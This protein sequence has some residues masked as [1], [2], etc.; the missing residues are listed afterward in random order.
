M[1]LEMQWSENGASGIGAAVECT[2]HCSDRLPD[3]QANKH[4]NSEDRCR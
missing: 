1:G 2:L 4:I 3:R